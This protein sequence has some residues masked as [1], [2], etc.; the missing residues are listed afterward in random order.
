MQ[1]NPDYSCIDIY[2]EE[3]PWICSDIRECLGGHSV[4]RRRLL[5]SLVHADR[6]LKSNNPLDTE[7]IYFNRRGWLEIFREMDR[8]Y[9]DL[10]I[11]PHIARS[12]WFSVFNELAEH[13]F[14]L[15][16]INPADQRGTLFAVNP[17]KRS[18]AVCIKRN[19][20]PNL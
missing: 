13:G 8:K 16:K 9:R 7:L 19:T 15:E 18:C 14:L 20:M 17:K 2:Y 3:R 11:I 12:S 6:Y 10:N 5:V 4:H 1:S